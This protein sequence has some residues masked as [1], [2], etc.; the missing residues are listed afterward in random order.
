MQPASP[1]TPYELQTVATP[2]PLARFSHRSRVVRS[3]ELS[4]RYLPKGGTFVDF[5]AGPGLLLH[6]IRQG[7]P[8]ATLIGV[9]PYMVPQYSE[10]ARFVTDFAEIP[11]QSVDLV[12]AFE[13]CEHLY[14]KEIH[15]FLTHARRTLRPN[16]KLLLSVPVMYGATVP[17]KVLNHVMLRGSSDFKPS[18]VL[19]SA[20]G[21]R[22]PRPETPRGTHK[23][24]DFRW[25]TQ[26]VREYFLIERSQFSPFPALPWFLSS[27]SFL[28][29]VP[30]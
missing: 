9:E 24:F 5:G 13:V 15:D 23:G 1:P 29:C 28:V 8:N 27:Q 3:L 16:G 11:S 14:T 7:D 26:V 6:Q 30:K 22:I 25:L 19:R 10:S 2:N 17:L 21:I 4:R 18:E 20:F 12:G